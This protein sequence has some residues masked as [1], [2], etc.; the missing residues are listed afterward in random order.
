MTPRKIAFLGASKG[1]GR[2]LA[3]RLA[4]RGDRLY[5]LGRD[6]EDRAK[7][8]HSEAR[9]GTD[10]GGT[11]VGVAVCDLERPETFAPALDAAAAGLGGLDT[12]VVTGGM[13]R[14][15]GQARGRS[16]ARAPAAHRRFRQHRRLLRGSAAAS[17]RPGRWDA[18]RLQLGRWRARAQAGHSVRRRQ[19][20]AHALPGGPGPQV[21]RARIAHRV[22]GAGIRSHRHDRGAAPA[23]L[24]RRA[25]RRRRPGPPRHRP[26]P[27]GGLC[28]GDFGRSS[29]GWNPP[30]AAVRYAQDR[31]LKPPADGRVLRWVRRSRRLNIFRPAPSKG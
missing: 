7:R 20:G 4:A 16:R 27:A 5:L 18:V 26:R 11:P 21:P 6:L 22:C 14:D 2:A 8:A 9:A 17:A 24:R 30:V 12:V 29:A 28:P 10:A 15:P 31:V 19:G 25:R 3:R 1:M 23:A 13:L